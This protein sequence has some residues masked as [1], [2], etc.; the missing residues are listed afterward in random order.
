MTA[1][2]KSKGEYI[3]MKIKKKTGLM[4]TATAAVAVCGIAAVSFAAWTGNNDTLTASAATG[5][6]YLFGF[7]SDQ[8]A[9]NLSLGTLVPYDQS[10]DSIKS[11]SKIVSVNVPAYSVYS[12]YDVTVTTASTSETM[13]FY[14]SV[15]EQQNEVPEGTPDTWTGWKEVTGDTA[16]FSF[17]GAVSGTEITDTYISLVLVSANN[18]DM[19]TANIAFTVTLTEAT[20]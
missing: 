1:N 3:I 16:K 8:S 15:G 2:E 10:E 17:T 19:N 6:A 20:V 11:G 13:T 14:V 7:T 4:L 18:G 5:E 9:A 12:D